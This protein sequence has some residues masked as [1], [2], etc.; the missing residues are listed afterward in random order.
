MVSQNDVLLIKGTAGAKAEKF[1]VIKIQAKYGRIIVADE[2]KVNHNLSTIL[3]DGKV[4]CG[5]TTAS[6][7]EV[8]RYFVINIAESKKWN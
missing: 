7:L 8:S 6:E 3:K 5:I 1:D 2:N 4:I